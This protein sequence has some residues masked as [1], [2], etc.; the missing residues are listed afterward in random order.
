MSTTRAA[1]ILL[2]VLAALAG[3]ACSSLAG[4]V[5][6]TAPRPCGALHPERRCLA[7]ADRALEGTAR[8]R[9][10]IAAILIVP[11]PPGAGDVAVLSARPIT[12]RLVFHDGTSRDA[13]MCGGLPDGPACFDEAPDWVK[14]LSFLGSGYSD[15]ACAGEPPEG[16]PSPI[17]GIDPEAAAAAEP[18][19]VPAMDIPIERTGQHAI[20]LGRG[21]LPNGVI[22]EASL[23]LPDPWPDDATFAEFGTSLLIR[24][25][26]PDGRPFINKYE[27]GW[28]EG[29][30]R[31]EA[32]I[33]F[34]VRRFDPGAVLRVEDVVVR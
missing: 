9:V 6:P 8:R 28:R 21:S 34:D 15:I 31:I 7:M 29:V 5:D 22:S 20:A 27:H 30:E 11:D 25:L 10:E 12:V 23:V 26:E 2:G 32:V 17:P 24:S 13:R 4:F 3:T 1:L 19:I 33:V 18:I 16:C 14:H